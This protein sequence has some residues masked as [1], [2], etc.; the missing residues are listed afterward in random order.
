MA[1]GTLKGTI[2]ALFL[3][4][5]VA[6][7]AAIYTSQFMHPTYRAKIKPTIEAMAALPTVVLG[8][9]PRPLACAL[10]E[11]LFPAL[12]GMALSV[13][14]VVIACALL[15]H[16]V[17]QHVKET[18]A[19]NRIIAARSGHRADHRGLPLVQSTPRPHL[20]RRKL[21]GLVAGSA[22]DSIRPT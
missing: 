18:H 22:R 4:I 19:G 1:F 9:S 13:P 21:Q 8:F 2:Y 11:R 10:L 12:I 5:P 17:P 3:A 7:L 16:L 20:V 14:I 6:I 15:W